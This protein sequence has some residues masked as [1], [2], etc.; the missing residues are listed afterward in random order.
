MAADTAPD[1]QPPS[2][3]ELAGLAELAS[4]VAQE[5]AELLLARRGHAGVVQTKS[6]P[7][8]VVT[9][10]DRAAEELIRRRLLA[11]RPGDTVLGE[12]GGEIGGSSPRA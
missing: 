6:S 9:E 2:G 8:D 4:S 1:P 3:P 11:A 7:T 5:A 10:M 12:E